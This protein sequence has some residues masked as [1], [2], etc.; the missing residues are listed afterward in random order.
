M[1]LAPIGVASAA[2]IALV[3]GGFALSSGTTPASGPEEPDTRTAQVPAQESTLARPTTLDER[4]T[5]KAP[6]L[7]CDACP[8]GKPSDQCS[9]TPVEARRDLSD[10]AVEALAAHI[11]IVR[12]RL[13]VVVGDDAI[14]GSS[15]LFM[16]ALGMTKAAAIAEMDATGRAEA[17][18]LPGETP[19]QTAMRRLAEAAE[20]TAT[21]RPKEGYRLHSGMY[22]YDIHRGEFPVLDR[23]HDLE[24]E[25]PDGVPPGEVP[26]EEVIALAERVLAIDVPAR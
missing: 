20:G 13:P 7:E 22:Q 24:K 2:T 18:V 11:D 4:T 5:A 10:E 3:A 14:D 12:R 17:L 26:L 25:W 21:E 23:L 15:D 9:A 1:N 8:E 6:E 19:E 16:E